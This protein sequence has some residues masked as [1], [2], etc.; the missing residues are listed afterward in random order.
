MKFLTDP[1]ALY[2][3]TGAVALAAYW[4]MKPKGSDGIN[5]KNIVLSVLLVFLGLAMGAFV[6]GTDPGGMAIAYAVTTGLAG[7]TTVKTVAERKAQRQ[8]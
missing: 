5:A 8:V 6:Q 3:I 2:W 4:L 1:N 7:G